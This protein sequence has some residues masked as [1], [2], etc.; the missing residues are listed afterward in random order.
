MQETSDI[1][2]RDLQVGDTVE[3][4]K[5]AST[6]ISITVQGMSGVKVGSIPWQA[7]NNDGIDLMGKPQWKTPSA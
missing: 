7:D 2:L 6:V 3:I 1:S 4:T 5:M